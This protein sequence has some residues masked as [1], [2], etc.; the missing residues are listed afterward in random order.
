[1]PAP[2]G[3]PRHWS[4]AVEYDPSA[5]MEAAMGTHRSGQIWVKLTVADDITTKNA[6]AVEPARALVVLITNE[7]SSLE[8]RISD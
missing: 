6:S 5:G 7:T 1:M 3:K 2:E 4:T 8:P